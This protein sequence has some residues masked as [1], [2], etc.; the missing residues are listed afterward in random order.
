MVQIGQYL[1]DECHYCGRELAWHEF[2]MDRDGKRSAR[3]RQCHGIATRTCVVCGKQ[4]IGKPGRKACSPECRK[5]MNPPTY[6]NCPQCGKCFGPVGHLKRKFCSVKCKNE[7]QKTGMKIIRKT[8]TKARRAHSLLRYH[9]LKG[10]IVK[11]SACEHCGAE[12][13][14][15]EGAHHDYD[16]PLEVEWLC[17]SCHA[18]MDKK[19]PKNVTFVAEVR[20]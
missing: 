20:T 1:K 12:D 5:R 4:F 13:R 11:P 2:Y 15:L 17:K 9:V 10:H 18:R 7:A 16:K 19:N 6:K 14:R 8:S 3:C